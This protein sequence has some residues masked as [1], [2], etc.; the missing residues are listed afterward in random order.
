M[1]PEKAVV[2]GPIIVF[3]VIFGLIIAGFLA[4]IIKLIAKTKNT[5]WKGK[6]IDKKY[7]VSEDMDDRTTEHYVLVVDVEGQRV[8]NIEVNRG[9]YDSCQAGDLLEKPLGK[10]NPVKI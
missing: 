7:R 4:F 9:L 3:F 10:L 1:Q 5:Y 6:V 8:R 2:F